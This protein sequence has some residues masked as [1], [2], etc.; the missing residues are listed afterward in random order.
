[1]ALWEISD[2]SISAFLLLI[3]AFI[4]QFSPPL[5]SFL[6]IEHNSIA[7]VIFPLFPLSTN[8]MRSPIAQ[9]NPLSENPRKSRSLSSVD[10]QISPS[11]LFKFWCL[12]SQI[13][14]ISALRSSGYPII[15]LTSHIP[16]R[17]SN[18]Y[19]TIESVD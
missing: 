8:S 4:P 18:C 9:K 14:R 10:T 6:Y 7:S 12:F 5:E 1:M 15:H 2:L 13:H 3:F 16:L 11:I 19:S 17:R